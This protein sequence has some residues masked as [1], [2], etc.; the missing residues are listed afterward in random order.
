MLLQPPAD[1]ATPRK[2]QVSSPFFAVHLQDI[3]LTNKFPVLAEQLFLIAAARYTLAVG[4]L[5]H[6]EP[7]GKLLEK[8]TPIKAISTQISAAQTRNLDHSCQLVGSAVYAYRKQLACLLPAMAP[9]IGVWTFAPAE[10]AISV[11]HARYG[12]RLTSSMGAHPLANLGPQL[13]VARRLHQSW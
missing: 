10:R 5:C 12:L 1:L 13:G 7:T 3:D 2:R 9:A 11:R 6:L 4:I 8:Q